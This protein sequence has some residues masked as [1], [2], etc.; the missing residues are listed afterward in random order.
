MEGLRKH[1]EKMK[2]AGSLKSIATNG[3]MVISGKNGQEILNF[4][5]DTLD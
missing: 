5:N 3:Q 4:Y 2:M 1:D